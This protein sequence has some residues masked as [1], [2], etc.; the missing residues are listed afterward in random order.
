MEKA[1][2]D[3][4]AKPSL[5]LMTI[6][7]Y[8]PVVDG[9]PVSFPVDVSKSAHAGLL[10][11]A[12]RNA[13]PFESSALGTNLYLNPWYTEPAG[14]PEIV[15]ATFAA[16]AGAAV[17]GNKAKNAVAMTAIRIVV[18]M[19]E[20]C[21]RQPRYPAAFGRGP[22]VLRHRLAPVLPFI[23]G[24][25]LRGRAKW[26]VTPGATLKRSRT[27]ANLQLLPHR[28]HRMNAYRCAPFTAVSS[29]SIH[30]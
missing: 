4:L 9:V 20:S 2:N 30:E 14:V 5:T 26:C 18:N 13:S 15:G 28:K 27:R 19:T 23:D 29:T 7:E 10:A 8:V 6:F 3:A 17:S 12:K 11:I 1:G 16:W 21:F 22:E 25:V 24:C